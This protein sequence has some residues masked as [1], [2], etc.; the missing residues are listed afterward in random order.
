MMESLMMRREELDHTIKVYL[1]TIPEFVYVL[2]NGTVYDNCLTVTVVFT[3][4]TWPLSLC[5]R[6]VVYF[7]LRSRR[8]RRPMFHTSTL[9]SL[10]RQPR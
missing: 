2:I 6:S 5:L 10:I 4:R 7:I 8:T 3:L 1:T 9:L